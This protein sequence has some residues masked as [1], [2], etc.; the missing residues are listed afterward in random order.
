[1]PLASE[2]AGS[3]ATPRPRVR[4][5]WVLPVLVGTLVLGLSAWV[6]NGWSDSPS[7]GRSAG[8][9]VIQQYPGDERA[10]LDSFE[11][12]LLDGG[13]F[14]SRDL[15]GRVVVYNVWGS[16]CVPCRT[17]APALIKVA[18]EYAGDVAFVG[19]NVRDGLEAARAFERRQEV[20]Y[21]S[22]RAEDSDAAL[23]AFGS[24]VAVAAVP[25]TVVVDRKG[26]IAGRVVGPTTYG[27]LK[28]LV[29]DVVQ[30]D[31]AAPPDAATKRRR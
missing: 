1:M 16:W 23:L 15:L 30:E 26:R 4:Q 8:E 2:R 22:V 20:P 12:R 21:P 29:A 17:E 14:S 3:D 10:E 6:V 25:T 7:S 11:G 18:E 5:R 13:E 28:A 27:T 9:A 24:S 31:A 19:I